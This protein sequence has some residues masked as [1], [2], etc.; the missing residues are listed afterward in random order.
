MAFLVIFLILF[1]GL[2]AFASS[3][4]AVWI[5]GAGSA[6]YWVF[7]SVFSAACIAVVACF[8]FSERLS[9]QAGYIAQRASGV[10]LA[11]Y[12]LLVPLTLTLGLAAS[13]RL[14][15]PMDKLALF[16]IILSAAGTVGGHFRASDIKTV[17]YTVY[18]DKHEGFKAVFLSDMH[19]G[20]IIG[21]KDM[22]KIAEAV[23]KAEPDYIFIS[24]DI[25]DSGP[26][27]LRQKDRVE[28]AFRSMKSRYGVYACLGNHDGGF[29]GL[30]DEAQRLLESWGVTVLRDQAVS[31]GGITIAGRRDLHEKG[32]VTAS[33]LLEGGG[34]AF[35]VVL[36]HQPADIYGAAGAGADLLLCG[37]THR[38]Q[39]FPFS[40]I[41]KAV[42]KNFHYGMK[43][44][45]G[46]TAV[47][48]S[49]AGTWGPKVRI[50]SFC[51]IVEITV[52]KA[53]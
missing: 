11:F 38:G 29:R 20:E 2:G 17:R 18:T 40:L 8:A 43:T 3:R 50:G 35:T 1:L 22:E 14:E 7:T 33:E 26:D 36:D 52:E 10:F 6:C 48:S 4:L 25:F 15:V 42:Y 44:A 27:V 41:T 39:I 37:H 51:E 13:G 53:V 31:A 46:M 34:D 49:G 32:R 23:N 12:A 45:D 47:I 16:L 9:G 5:F 19:L 30:E 28:K 21:G 24:G